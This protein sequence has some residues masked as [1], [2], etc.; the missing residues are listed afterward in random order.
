MSDNSSPAA[1]TAELIWSHWQRG[2]VLGAL[3]AD[4]RPKTR[5]EGYAAQ[6]ALQLLSTSAMIGWKIAAT[7]ANGQAHIGV[8]GPIA[9]RLFK[10]RV[11]EDG[12]VLPIIGSRM[13][14]AEPEFAFRMARDLPPRTK[15][16][17]VN[18][19]MAAVATL[20]PAIE[21]PDSRFSDFAKVGE[22]QLIADNA[23][24]H[25]VVIGR[26]TD[27]DWRGVDLSQHKA[28]AQV[29]GKIDR[30]G[31]GSNV[32]GDPRLALTWLTNELSGLGITLAAGQVVITGTCAAPLAI[33]AGDRLLMDFGAFGKVSATL[34]LE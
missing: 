18:E 1:R 32:L 2:E 17:T 24:T 33:G 25:Q 34:G 3:P 5:V 7:S 9:G 11:Y 14:V 19:V 20:H 23:C 22:A 12:A 30:E 4:I 15:L 13:R 27:A 8:P 21:V 10:E 29:V 6:A 16:Y 31:I 26:A 28:R